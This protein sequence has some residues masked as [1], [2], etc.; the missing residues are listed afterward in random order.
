MYEL[1]GAAGA[2]AWEDVAVPHAL[3]YEARLRVYNWLLRWLQ[4]GSAEVEREPRVAPERDEELWVSERGNA[5][6]QFG[7]L[8]PFERNREM[9]RRTSAPEKMPEL[10][11]LLA[12]AEPPPGLKLAVLGRTRSRVG[13]LDAVEVQT[14]P[15]MW[16]PAWLARPA[17]GAKSGCVVVLDPAGR[18]SLWQEGGVLETL[19][20]AGWAACAPDLRGIGD[21]RGEYPRGSVRHAAD[22]ANE[23]AY[24]WASLWLGRPVVGQRVTDILALVRALRNEAGWAG[25]R[26]WIAANGQLTAPALYAAS[27]ETA[28]S[29]LY[30]SSPLLS[31]RAVTECEEYRHPLSNFV[32]GLLKRVDLPR[33]VRSIAP[34][35]VVLAGVLSGAGTPAAAE[36]AAR[37]Y[38]GERHVRVAPKAEWS[39]RGILAQLAGQP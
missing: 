33:V 20:E 16:A 22:H 31:F 1:L 26:M 23:E 4:P 12:I 11:E 17:S 21:L 25:M 24:A 30:L 8:T 13:S 34:R 38:G 32:P 37:A 36:E 15:A 2:I 5:A 28:I 18:N 19:A 14:G 35:P 9:A 27:M 3:G 7:G 6:K 39:G 29:G 10:R